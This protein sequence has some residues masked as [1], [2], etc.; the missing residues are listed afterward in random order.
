MNKAFKTKMTKMVAAEE[1]E[2]RRLDEVFERW[3]LRISFTG[4]QTRR[5]EGNA[6]VNNGTA[7]TQLEQIFEASQN[8]GTVDQLNVAIG[9]AE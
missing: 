6:G 4:A 3:F 2:F 5:A 9:A 7:F 8:P 1:N